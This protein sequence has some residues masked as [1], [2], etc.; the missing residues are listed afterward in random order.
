MQNNVYLSEACKA[1]GYKGHMPL[2][3]SLGEV[4]N[5]LFLP[6][7]KISLKWGHRRQTPK[8]VSH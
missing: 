7:M 4:R 6:R 1:V 2:K 3:I 8:L 5:N